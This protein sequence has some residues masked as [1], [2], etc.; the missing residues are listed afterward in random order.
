MLVLISID[1]DSIAYA[2]PFADEYMATENERLPI[3]DRS[4]EEKEVNQIREVI[5]KLIEIAKGAGFD[6]SI[7]SALTTQTQVPSILR[8]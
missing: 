4:L 8:V 2:Y 3:K 1:K 5:D 6:E 7:S